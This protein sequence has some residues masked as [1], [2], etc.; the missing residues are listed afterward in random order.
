MVQIQS[1]I[2]ELLVE[3]CPITKAVADVLNQ[4]VNLIGETETVL[5]D[6]FIQTVHPGVL[7]LRSFLEIAYV[8]LD[9]GH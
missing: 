8:L 3:F 2:L 9:F 7:I 5:I 4:P 6:L 1:Q